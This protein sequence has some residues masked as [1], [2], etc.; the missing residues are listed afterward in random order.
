LI[1]RKDVLVLIIPIEYSVKIILTYILLLLGT[2]IGAQ[3]AQA[4]SLIFDILQDSLEVI[5]D[6]ELG[7]NLDTIE[8]QYVEIRGKVYPVLISE[9]DTM[10]LA[11]IEDVSISSPRTFENSDDYKRYRK[12]KYY[13]AKVYPF[14]LE[15]IKV[16]KDINY[17]TKDMSKRKRRKY[18]KARDKELKTKFEDPLKGLSKTQG[19]ILVKMIERELDVEMY[20]VIKDFRGKFKAMYWNQSS[21]LLGY[22]LKHGYHKGENPILDIVLQD[23]DIS[24][25][26]AVDE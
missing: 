19:K 7:S 12:Y 22:R 20:D 24:Y 15:A 17:A 21:K 18:I 16:Y 2:T 9:G 23:F 14:A 10:V 11:E 25:E 3:S 26:V 4:D 13:A 6:Y 1:N 8:T 5:E